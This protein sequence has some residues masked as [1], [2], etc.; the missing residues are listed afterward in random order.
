[1]YPYQKCQ[2]NSNFTF[3]KSLDTLKM[4]LIWKQEHEAQHHIIL[5]DKSTTGTPN[6]ETKKETAYEHSFST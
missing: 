2:Q 1:M 3:H 6:I 5:D 4:F